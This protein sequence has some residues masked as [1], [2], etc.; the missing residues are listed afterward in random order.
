MEFLQYLSWV[1]GVI[2]ELLVIGALSRGLYRRF[3]FVFAYCTTLFLTTVVE[4][5]AKTASGT[6]FRLLFRNLYWIDEIIS[7]ILIFCLVLDLIHQA[8]EASTKRRPIRLFVFAVALVVPIA[9]FLLHY[10]PDLRL[11]AWMTLVSRDM[12]FC[13]VILDLAL[14][15]LLIAARKKDRLLL[16]VTGALGV[17]FTGAAIGQ[18]LRHLSRNTVAFGNLVL[19]F[20][21]LFCLYAWWQAF[22]RAPVVQTARAGHP[23]ERS[24]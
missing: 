17:Q 2:L 3:P 12:S 20:S 7:Q 14:W 21:S 6:H 13:S 8:S 18:S 22:R 15:L 11:N 5:A 19:V 23:S 24:S 1:I 9:S 4:V 16:L 10:R